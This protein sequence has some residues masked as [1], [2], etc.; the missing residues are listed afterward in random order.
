MRKARGAS[1]Y[2]PSRRACVA[3]VCRLLPV[4]SSGHQPNRAEAISRLL[5]IG[6]ESAVEK[7]LTNGSFPTL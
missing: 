5:E 7:K 6:A 1:G 4:R 2:R 3:N